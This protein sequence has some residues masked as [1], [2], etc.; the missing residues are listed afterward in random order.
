MSNYI[1]IILNLQIL[2]PFCF[3]RKIEKVYLMLFGTIIVL[4][5]VKLCKGFPL[6]ITVIGRGLC[7]KPVEI[8]EKRATE[9][10]K[11]SSILD[12]EK[13]LLDRLQSSINAL[14]KAAVIAKECFIDLGSF[15]ED[16]R[17]PAVV[18]ID[19]WSELYGLQED[20]LSIAYL[21]DLNN[22]SLANLTVTRYVGFYCLS[23]MI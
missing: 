10:S 18:L 13:L 4:Q 12:S 23:G 1:F 21:H 14:D 8:W 6:A 20:H 17:I 19:M 15:P 16:R 2:I 22:R 9:L 7:N 11:G 3:L 5:I